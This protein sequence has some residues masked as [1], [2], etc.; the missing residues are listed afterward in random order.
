MEIQFDERV[1]VEKIEDNT[2]TLTIRNTTIDD[3]A[4]Y[5]C[6]AINTAGKAKTTSELLVNPAGQYM[7]LSMFVTSF[8]VNSIW[9]MHI[10]W[11]VFS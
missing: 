7:F 1:T 2:Y 3:E 5:T 10:A 11:S 9:Y 4:D 8:N 6:V